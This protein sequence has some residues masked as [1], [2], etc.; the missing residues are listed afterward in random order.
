[1]R[2]LL[3]D[4]TP[5]TNYGIQLR[6][7]DGTAQ[8]EWSRIF[9]ITTAAKTLAPAT[10]AN[11]AWVVS[12]TSFTATWDAVTLNAD[13]SPLKDLKTYR[14]SI[15][16]GS[17]TVVYETT[18]TRFDFTIEMNRA[19]FGTPKASLSAFVRAVD[20]SLNQSVASPTLLAVNPAPTQPT[21]FVAVGIQDNVSLSWSP[22]SDDDLL[23]YH[24]Y[25]STAGSGFAPDS[26]NLVWSGSATSATIQ[27][28]A[29]GITHYFKLAAYDVFS[30]DSSYAIADAIPT[31]S[32]T[33]DTT[34]PATP[35]SL[36]LTPTVSAIDN[37]LVDVK[38]TWIAPA[39]TDLGGYRV[40]FRIT[41]SS[42]P[43]QTVDVA[44]DVTEAIAKNL[45]VGTSY[46]FQVQSYDF[47]ANLSSYTATATTSTSNTAPS[48]PAV[49]TIAG[50]VQ[51]FGI[52]HNM[53]KAAGGQLETD[54]VAI[55]VYLGT[56]NV[57]ATASPT[58]IYTI[59]VSK[60]SL[61]AVSDKIVL[62][63]ADGTAT[64]YIYVTAVDSAG[65]EGTNSD[66]VSLSV[67]S[68]TGTYIQDATITSAKIASL[69]ADKITA[70]TGIINDLLVKSKLEVSTG[71]K[72]QSALY[73]TSSGVS[74][75]YM[76]DDEFILKSGAIEAA[77]LKIQQGVNLVPAQ[78]AGFEFA[79]SFYVVRA[80]TGSTVT[81]QSLTVD[82]ATIGTITVAASVAQAKF[83]SQSLSMVNAGAG[84]RTV[85][86]TGSTATYPQR[87][88]T[89]AKYILSG[90][91][92]NNSGST[93]SISMGLQVFSGANTVQSF[94][95]TNG[96]W[97]RF[98]LAIPAPATEFAYIYFIA[99]A[100]STFYVDGIQMEEQ[101]GS[102][103][104]PSAWKPPGTTSIDGAIIRTGEIRSNS[105]VT[106]NSVSQPAWSIN[107]QGGAQFGTVNVR[108]SLVV[109]AAG[110]ADLD[111]GQSTAQSSNWVDGV[112]G[113]RID[114]AGNA[115]FN[116][117]DAYGTVRSTNY[118][119]GVSGW[120]VATD[121]N[122]QF[123]NLSVQGELGV[124]TVTA[125]TIWVADVNGDVRDL[126]NDIVP[127][128][129][130][131]VGYG[132]RNSGVTIS[133]S[134]VGIMEFRIQCKAGYLYVFE[135]STFNG[136]ANATS[137]AQF[138]MRYTT[139]GTKPTT[140]T[141]TVLKYGWMDN[142]AAAGCNMTLAL[143]KI[144]KPAV[145]T[146]LW[147]LLS[148][149]PG[150]GS[151][152]LT[153]SSTETIEMWAYECGPAPD[154]G[155]DST[156]SGSGSDPVQTYTK[157]YLANW[158]QS[159]KSSGA[160]RT[161]NLHLYQGYVDSFN[162]NQWAA[163]GFPYSTIASDLTGATVTS[164]K[165]TF[166]VLHT[167]ANSGTSFK[168]GTHNFTAKPGTWN[169]TGQNDNL[170]ARTGVAGS[171]YTVEMGTTVGAAFKT[172]TTAR[173]ICLGPTTAD[174][175]H[176]GYIGGYN[177]ATP[178]LTITYR[179]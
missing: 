58:L 127:S 2:I 41:G 166:K 5:G 164:C 118:I 160:Q 57:W 28:F 61:V 101:I 84:V 7:T 59:N 87:L 135:T 79:S 21:D 125:D 112:S 36:V 154:I 177:D 37:S 128:L 39:D 99:P 145:D 175:A 124:D 52:A 109:G 94:S 162:G 143:K 30:T 76:D 131:V 141:S 96:F 151:I 43:W 91:F 161:D 88:D 46:D 50:S 90:Y 110:G 62:P 97:Q 54:V 105:N 22:V 16:D 137:R 104:T 176:Y 133:G 170:A 80:A 66:A 132:S 40:R 81:G 77:A 92:Y 152:A 73:T 147:I 102:I 174:N 89:S 113:W 158:S 155:I 56:T 108:G 60:G 139:N 1:M 85:S 75:F 163:I 122:A 44:P 159:Y 115:Q 126:T 35:T 120:Q 9:K 167:Y 153:G 123:Q 14:L 106:V 168:I 93:K 72:I 8:G 82:G 29:F 169:G 179:K 114:S 65:L 156:G 69:A 78:Y 24:V 67:T 107:T 12:G 49:P 70:G 95:V 26:S 19:A 71:G 11:F 20:L 173:G 149:A 42:D 121:G 142:R 13:S 100:T 119:E 144:Y 171:T 3:R 47:S 117:L 64:R 116:N 33:V 129:A 32:Y 48:K 63:T 6:G 34:A 74:G 55:K 157:K 45:L 25:M 98:S 53:Q 178:Y 10:P 23:G 165:F 51:S 111:A 83:E 146:D 4:L 172:G 31:S 136:V 15:T 148:A 140:A 38:A 18:A 86:L 130:R 17:S 150:A 134:E 27:T 138:N 103:A 68:I